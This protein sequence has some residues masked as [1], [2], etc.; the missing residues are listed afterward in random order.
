MRVDLG[1]SWLKEVPSVGHSSLRFV[2]DPGTASLQL[3]C[4]L[5]RRHLMPGSSK[6]LLASW[7]LLAAI[8]LC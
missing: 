8:A 4:S 7:S 5:A 6:P 1:K 3:R 2:T